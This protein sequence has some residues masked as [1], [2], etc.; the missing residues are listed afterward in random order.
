MSAAEGVVKGNILQR[1]SES[2]NSFAQRWIPS[3]LVLAI[4]L[5]IFVA[6]LSMIV[7][8]SSPLTVLVAWEKGFWSLLAFAMQMALL[9]LT[10]FIVADSPPIKRLLRRLARIPNNQ[11]TAL[12]LIVV[13]SNIITFFNTGLGNI[14]GAMIGREMLVAARE[15][16]YKLHLP[17]VVA[18]A[19]AL[20]GNMNGLGCAAQLF[21][22]TP[23]HFMEKLIGVLPLTQTSLLPINLSEFVVQMIVMILLLRGM[24]PKAEKCLE[25]S[26]EFVDSIKPQSVLTPALNTPAMKFNY[27][28]ILG[29]GLG[30]IALFWAARHIWLN[31]LAGINFNVSNFVFLFVGLVLHRTPEHF[32]QSAARGVNIVVAILVQF[33]LYA[34][35]FGIITNTGLGAA[36]TEF[37]VSI[38]NGRIFPFIA[39]LYSSI[40]NMFVPS[41]GSKFVIEAPYIIPAAQELGVQASTIINAY[42][43]GDNTTNIIQPFWAL[44]VLSLFKIDFKD[45]LPY[46]FVMALGLFVVN[47]VYFGFLYPI[48][49]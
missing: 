36:L 37:F 20:N 14:S 42:T 16:G 39:Y 8:K 7:T 43:M 47:I 17:L 9:F 46:T 11:L 41:G 25:A 3:A 28:K 10:G 40:L 34:G 30:I 19:L 27:S 18:A 21:V 13:V 29:I 12:L 24:A 5:T 6:I 35:M 48:F 23:G 38:S 44:P 45:V 22:A 31:G 2:F 4:F 26:D 1:M 32:M 33:P 49:Y 15:K